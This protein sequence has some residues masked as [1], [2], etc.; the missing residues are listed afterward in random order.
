M[1][2]PTYREYTCGCKKA[3]L[4]IYCPGRYQR[5]MHRCRLFTV[6]PRALVS[7]RHP[8]AY[9]A[10]VAS[11]KKKKLVRKLKDGVNKTLEKWIHLE[12]ETEIP[13]DFE[14]VGPIEPYYT[15]GAI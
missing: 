8:C 3:D 2:Y 13:G 15:G 7:F 10:Y 5:N 1:C 9:H 4:I 6:V 11:P 14:T 12:E